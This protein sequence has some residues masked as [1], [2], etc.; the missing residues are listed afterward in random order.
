M[1]LTIVI[2][3]LVELNCK[4]YQSQPAFVDGCADI[5]TV[6][7]VFLLLVPLVLIL[8]HV[9]ICDLIFDILVQ[10]IFVVDGVKILEAFTIT[11][12]V[13]DILLS[14]LL[15]N[16]QFLD[17]VSLSEAKLGVPTT[18][19]SFKEKQLLEKVWLA[20]ILL[21]V[22]FWLKRKQLLDEISFG[23]MFTDRL[24]KL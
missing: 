22:F 14:F 19:L 15:K 23:E 18:V 11:E 16:H 13:L 24:R 6:V 2:V 17:Q 9:V 5:S 21:E 10:E 8:G 3:N 4:N 20:G 7:F 12:T 1:S